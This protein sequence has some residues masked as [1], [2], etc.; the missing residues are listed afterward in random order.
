MATN[1]VAKMKQNYLPPALIALSIRNG[2]GY[3]YL[4]VRVISTNDA[5]ISR[6][7]FV[8]CGPVTPEKTGLICV[9]FLRH[10]KKLA[11]LVKYLRI[12][13]TDFYNLFTI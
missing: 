11:Y 7:N 4:N 9:L 6:K 8:N 2:M 13:W 3:R 1:L 12:Y 5:S 10:G